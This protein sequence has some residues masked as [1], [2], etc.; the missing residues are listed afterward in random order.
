L[1]A[2]GTLAPGR[3]HHNQVATLRGTWQPC[4]ITGRFDAA[5]W[6]V[7]GGFP[8]LVWDPGA[9][10]IPAYLLESPDLPREWSRLDGFEGDAYVRQVLPVTTS[11]GRLLANVYTIRPR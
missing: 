11:A 9:P 5:G 8:G 1:V 2:Y 6:G 7:T 3:E 10:A 4:T